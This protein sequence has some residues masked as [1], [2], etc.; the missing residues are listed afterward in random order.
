MKEMK[1]EFL[2]SLFYGLLII[3]GAW[4]TVWGSYKIGYSVGKMDFEREY[5]PKFKE[6]SV[7]ID[8][9]SKRVE[10]VK[11]RQLKLNQCN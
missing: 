7:L 4:V 11:Q 9:L 5:I 3:I 1:L 8:S 10:R 6:H 2:M